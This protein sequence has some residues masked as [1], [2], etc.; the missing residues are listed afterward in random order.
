MLDFSKEIDKRFCKIAC[1]LKERFHQNRL[2]AKVLEKKLS[3]GLKLY[4]YSC[5]T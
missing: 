5:F 3:N 4:F 1:F 2:L